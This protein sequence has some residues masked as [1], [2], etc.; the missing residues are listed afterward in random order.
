VGLDEGVL[1]VSLARDFDL[2]HLPDDFYDDPYPYY[3]ALRETNPVKRMPDGSV[4]LSRYADLLATRSANSLRNLDR[5]R[6]SSAII[7]RAWSSTTRP[8]MRACAARSW[9]H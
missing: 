1:R 9:A 4:F 8:I 6:D 5:G 7:L 2:R 3:R